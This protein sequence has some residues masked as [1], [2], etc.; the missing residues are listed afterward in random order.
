MD[1]AAAAAE[2][3][4]EGDKKSLRVGEFNAELAADSGKFVAA[5]VVSVGGAARGNGFAEGYNAR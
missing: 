4:C 3:S 1:G 2:L 5:A